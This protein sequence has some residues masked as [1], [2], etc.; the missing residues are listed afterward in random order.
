RQPHREADRGHAAVAGRELAQPTPEP[1]RP[2]GLPDV[3]RTGRG[4]P[5]R[6]HQRVGRAVRRGAA[7]DAAPGGQAGLARDRGR[8]GGGL[9]PRSPRRLGRRQAREAAQGGAVRLVRDQPSRPGEARD[10]SASA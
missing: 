9:L 1:R 10:G 3:L 8:R 2:Q 5:R 4:G 7:Q 6:D